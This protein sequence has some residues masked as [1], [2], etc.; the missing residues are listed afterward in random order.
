MRKNCLQFRWK[1]DTEGNYDPM[2]TRKLPPSRSHAHIFTTAC[3]RCSLI[4][5]S[6]HYYATLCALHIHFC[7]SLSCVRVR[8]SLHIHFCCS[9]SCIKFCVGVYYF[10]QS[11]WWHYMKD[12]GHWAVLKHFIFACQLFVAEMKWT[13]KQVFQG[14]KNVHCC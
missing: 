12:V 9:V 14:M 4:P 6:T 13:D 2:K 11:L 8:V 3:S 5:L 1:Q 7:C 10:W